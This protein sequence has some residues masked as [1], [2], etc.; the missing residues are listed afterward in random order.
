MRPSFEQLQERARAHLR[1]TAGA[2]AE[3]LARAAASVQDS[4]RR[5]AVTLVTLLGLAAAAATASAQQ[6]AP[7]PSALPG[8]LSAVQQ[9]VASVRFVN[10]E[11]QELVA[12][13]E[14]ESPTFRAYMEAVRQSGF[15]VTFGTWEESGL[16]RSGQGQVHFL[17]EQEGATR[18]V[19]YTHELASEAWVLVDLDSVEETYQA[20]LPWQRS[21]EFQRW[22][23]RS[24]KKELIG[25]EVSHLVD[26]AVSGGMV[27][28]LCEDP[29]RDAPEPLESC[30][31]RRHRQLNEEMGIPAPE[32]YGGWVHEVNARYKRA[33]KESQRT[34]RAAEPVVSLTAER[35]RQDI[36]SRLAELEHA[37][38]AAGRPTTSAQPPA[39]R[40]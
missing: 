20:D 10:P 35:V 30:V 37:R 25:H 15:P 13:M 14:Q 9:E 1:K 33:W 4:L 23:I 5:D 38:S 6:E 22:K 31:M 12:E 27:Q 34:P 32:A 11:M 26:V 40:R 18:P 17:R 24:L 21:S 19:R 8:S 7:L 3:D 29:A 2:R 39:L 36:E 28:L 16:R